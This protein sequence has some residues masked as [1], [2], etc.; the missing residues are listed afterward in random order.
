MEEGGTGGSPTSPRGFSG[1]W[2]SALDP[3]PY[4]QIPPPS[5]SPDSLSP[6]TAA[7]TVVLEQ[8][9]L[10]QENLTQQIFVLKSRLAR[11][12]QGILTA[13]L[14]RRLAIYREELP[15]HPRLRRLGREELSASRETIA[16]RLIVGGSASRAHP[17]PQRPPSPP[18]RTGDPLFFDAQ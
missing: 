18:W 1:I 6:S 3:D 12:R 15:L 5:S 8:L 16:F 17:A 4:R 10:R 2:I 14:S 13:T 9:V 11:Y 7:L